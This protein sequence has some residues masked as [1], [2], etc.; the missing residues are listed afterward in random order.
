[1]KYFIEKIDQSNR[2]VYYKD[3]WHFSGI[4]KWVDS[5]KDAKSFTK[6]NAQAVLDSK[7]FFLNIGIRETIFVTGY[8]DEQFFKAVLK[9]G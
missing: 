6:E 4:P 1:M 5:I 9:D 3:E 2:K 7:E 8:T